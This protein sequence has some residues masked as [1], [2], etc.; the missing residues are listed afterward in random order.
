MKHQLRGITKVRKENA[1]TQS[2]QLAKMASP[3]ADGG[4]QTDT[5]F[6]IDPNASLVVEQPD[7]ELLSSSDDAKT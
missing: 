5:N 6:K 2:S 4:R 1:G 3:V 7:L